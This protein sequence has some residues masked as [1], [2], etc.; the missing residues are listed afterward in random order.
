MQGEIHIFQGLRRDNHQIRQDNKYLWNAHNIRLTNRDDNTAFSITNERGTFN[1]HITFKGLYVGHCTLDKYLIVFTYDPTSKDNYIYRVEFDGTS[2]KSIILFKGNINKPFTHYNPIEAI[3]NYET[4]F[5]QK[6]YWVDG[7]NQPRV[8][9]IAKPELKIPKEYLNGLVDLSGPEYSTSLEANN[10]FK[11]NYPTGL[12]SPTEFEF[13]Q[14]LSLKET[15]DVWRSEGV[16][17]FSPG[18]IQ[19]AFSYYNKYGQETNIFYV[20]PLYYISP[21]DRGGN[22]E[23]S[24]AN[25]FNIQVNKLDNFEYLRIYSIHRTSI[26]ATPLVKV[27]EDIPINKDSKTIT[28]SDSGTKGY[29]IDPTQLLYIGGKDITADTIVHKDGTLFL[30]NITINDISNNAESIIK[31]KYSFEDIIIDTIEEDRSKSVYYRYENQLHNGNKAG[32]KCNETYRCGLQVQTSDGNWSN[33][34]FLDDIKLCKEYPFL[35]GIRKSKAIKISDKNTINSLLN[36]GVKRLR[37]CVVFPKAYERDVICQGVLCPTVYSLNNRKNGS[38]YAQSSWFFRPVTSVVNNSDT[39][40]ISPIYENKY[41]AYIQFAHNKPLLY[42]NKFGAEIQSM[43]Y[44]DQ[45]S[46]V[47]DTDKEGTYTYNDFTAFHFVDENIVTLNSPDVEFNTQ[48]QYIDWTNSRLRIIGVTQLGA[49]SGDIDI[50]TSTPYAESDTSPSSLGLHRT[51]VGYMTN[52]NKDINGGLVSGLFYN[53]AFI[54]KVNNE[55]KPESNSSFMVYPWH[56]TGSLNNDANRPEGSVGARSAVLKKKVI[57]NLKFFDTNSTISIGDNDII[58]NSIEYNI[59]TPKLFNSDRLE[60]TKLQTSYFTKEVPYMGNIDTLIT[61]PKEYDI[62]RGTGFDDRNITTV[63]KLS[64]STNK[65]YIAKTS[66]PIRMKYKSSPHL[67]FSLSGDA[68]TIRLLPGY[69]ERM[70]AEETTFE[71]PKWDK[72]A[73]EEFNDPTTDAD[74]YDGVFSS[75]NCGALNEE[76][77]L[78]HKNKYSY[79]RL[80]TSNKSLYSIGLCREA[81]NGKLYWDYKGHDGKII[82]VESNTTR[83]GNYDSEFSFPDDL[84]EPKDKEYIYKGEQLT[85][86]LSLDLA[87]STPTNEYYTLSRITRDNALSIKKEQ[88]STTTPTGIYTLKR[89]VFNIDNIV[90]DTSEGEPKYPFIPPYL[91]LAEIVRDIPEEVKFG[92]KSKEALQQNLWIPSSKSI[93]LNSTDKY[94]EIPFEYGDTWYSRYDCLKTYPYTSEDENQ[95]VEIGSFMC[96]TR[97]NIDGRYDRNRG[98]LSNLNMSPQNFNILNEVY[99]QSDNFFNYRILD[100]DYYKQNKFTHQ[101]TWSKEKSAGESIDTWTNINLANTLDLNGDKGKVTSI[102]A[103]NE[104]LICFQEKAVNLILFNSRAQIPV[105]DG[106]PIEISNGYKVDGSRL[107]SSSIGCTNKWSIITTALGIYFIDSNTK[108]IC[109]FNGN[110]SY[111]SSEK[112]MSWWVKSINTDTIWSPRSKMINGIRSFYDSKRG[113]VYFTP[114]LSSN[115]EDALCYSE[116]IGQFISFM[117]YGG[118]QAMFNFNNDF[119][120]LRNSDNTTTLYLNNLGEYNQFF[121]E[122]KSWDIS[123][124]SNDNPTVTKIFDNIEMRADTFNGKDILYTCP[125]N[126]I[127]VENEYQNGHSEVTKSNMRNKF[128]IWRGNIPRHL[129]TMQRIRNPWSMITIGY[130]VSNSEEKNNKTII[131]DISVKYTI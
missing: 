60:L 29:T 82:I 79:D 8:I 40:V 89:E 19:Y 113:D 112:G 61:S 9:N 75:I 94:I 30:G 50:D 66:E 25:V 68:N 47:T 128:R 77:R 81:T 110:L 1:T 105:T 10:Y 130:D 96:E 129:N 5:I 43:F 120:S 54:N 69:K 18:T 7:V 14:S 6:I 95:V 107:I 93:P 78:S 86:R 64:E 51:H 91:L 101:I 57:S 58:S 108:N 126:Y 117:S 27:L 23:E 73:N 38:I 42:N 36:L 97:V 123:F 55:Y 88:K 11:Q 100:E 98:Q 90:P 71:F 102:V 115:Q 99:S 20:T 103:W 109:L 59:S 46:D 72:I 76:P 12:Y 17:M 28:Y 74:F 119:I 3:G 16:G 125:I 116:N 124:I 37:S 122:D 92:G 26:D 22:P 131:H 21:I 118:T 35:S 44:N 85:Y 24:V 53:S 41:G 62:Y 80:D 111:L 106:V 45:V 114:G 31:D 48:L 33:P 83:I 121:D 65:N 70:S 127:S 84:P 49:I 67:V 63:G 2:Y 52:N 32:F 13:T 34:I 15:I 39:A 56:R 87:S 4:E 104:N